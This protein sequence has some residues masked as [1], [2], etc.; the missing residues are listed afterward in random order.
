[1]GY[2][3]DYLDKKAYNNKVGQY[4]FKREF[5]FIFNNGKSQLE[6][7]LDVAGG[8]GRFAIPL[9]KHSDQITVLDANST[10]LQ[11]LSQ[12]EPE[13]NTILGDFMKMDIHETFSLILCVEALGYFQNWEEFFNK[14]QLLMS[15]DARFIFTYQNPRSWRFLLRKLKHWRTGFYEYKE[16]DLMQLTELLNKCNL[17]IVKMEGMN[18]IP[19]SL[20]S[21][22]K[23]VSLFERTEKIFK[24]YSW[25][26]Q[27]PW[28]L[29][30]LKKRA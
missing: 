15:E 19:L 20:A 26:S 12:R 4:K 6:N 5:D 21:N 17:E 30:S 7:I 14:I 10:A 18:W 8:S 2:N 29:F 16:M 28:I 9:S 11:L 1:M 23:L 3:W 25:H 13:I 24:L 22:S 27:S